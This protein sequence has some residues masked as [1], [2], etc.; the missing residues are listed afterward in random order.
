MAAAKRVSRSDDALC[1]TMRL[2]ASPPPRP[3]HAGK[4]EQ[5]VGASQLFDLDPSFSHE[6]LP[7]HELHADL[8]SELVRLV[9][10]RVE[11]EEV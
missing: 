10:D 7:L 3:H 4:A 5:P 8:L 6:L 9:A 11:A 1:G 2:D